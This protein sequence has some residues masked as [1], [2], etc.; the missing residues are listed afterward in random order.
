MEIRSRRQNPFL[1]REQYAKMMQQRQPSGAAKAGRYLALAGP[2]AKAL[3]P[4]MKALASSDMYKNAVLDNSWLPAYGDS[5]GAGY[6]RDMGYGQFDSFD[7]G[8]LTTDPTKVDKFLSDYSSDI[9]NQEAAYNAAHPEASGYVYDTASQA[10]QPAAVVS[11][12][13]PV[14][15]SKITPVNYTAQVTQPSAITTAPAAVAQSAGEPLGFEA[16]T[17]VVPDYGTAAT[18]AADSFA[19]VASDVASSLWD[20]TPGSLSF[21]GGLGSSFGGGLGSSVGEGLGEAA[22]GSLWDATP[23]ISEMT[24]HVFDAATADLGYNSAFAAASAPAGEAAAEGISAPVSYDWMG[25]GA[26]GSGAMGGAASVAS[27]L[28]AGKSVNIGKAVGAAGGGYA[29]AAIGTAIAPG[30]GTVVGSVL[31]STIG[32]IFG[33]GSAI[34]TEM[35]RQGYIS[36]R[37]MQ[38]DDQFRK[39]VD[40]DTV[41]GYQIWAFPFARLM[42]KSRILSRISA[43][44]V[45]SWA[46]TMAAELAPDEFKPRFTGKCMMAIGKPICKLIGK[47]ARKFGVEA[48]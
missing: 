5:S 45:L 12:A 29:G 41:R 40:A 15:F 42:R 21:G 34:C 20:A 35:H 30:P 19:P 26:I 1:I 7:G 33:G 6:A 22:A 10:Y 47:I 46:F 17:A 11:S 38:L 25:S 27:D 14:D 18:A 3:S 9:S 23:A 4:A 43:P 24:P 16:A 32:S 48:K 44:F 13:E 8:K 28:L 31:G 2:A 37:I 39:S 36:D